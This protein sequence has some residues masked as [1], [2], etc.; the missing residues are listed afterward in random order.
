LGEFGVYG[1]QAITDVFVASSRC[2]CSRERFGVAT[3]SRHWIGI[4]GSAVEDP[5]VG[6]VTSLHEFL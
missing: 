1:S 3:P 4:G 5:P 2:R 6:A